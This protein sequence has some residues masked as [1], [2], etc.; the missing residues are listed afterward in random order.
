MGT[1]TRCKCGHIAQSHNRWLG[2]GEAPTLKQLETMTLEQRNAREVWGCDECG[3]ENCT[4][5]LR[6]NYPWPKVL[7]YAG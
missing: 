7:P 4:S 2:K 3:C 5:E 1:W 6:G